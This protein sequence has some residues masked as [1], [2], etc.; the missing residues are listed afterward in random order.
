MKDA[1]FSFTSPLFHSSLLSTHIPRM[2]LFGKPKS[3]KE[4]IQSI[5]ENLLILSSSQSKPEKE[6]R[7]AV[8]NIAVSL[9]NLRELLT[10]KSDTR[11]TGRERDADL[12]NSERTRINEI[13]TDITHEL[14]NLN[15]LPLLIANLDAIEFES[16]KHVVDLFGH[17]MRRQVGSYN[18]CAQYLLANPNILV[19]LLHGYSRPDR[20]IHYGAILRDACRHES[21]A[22]VVLSSP[23]FYQL[24]DY[25]QGTAFDVSSDAF[26]TLKDL[27]TRHKTL[28]AEF[29]STNYD[30][31]FKHYSN[32]IAA[33]NYV[34]NRQALK[35]LG[36]LLL[37][38][39]NFSV[40]TR[41]IAD[42]EN[43]KIIMNLLKSE[44]KQ[45][46][47]EAFHCFKVFVA[48]P[49]KPQSVHMILFRNQEKLISFLSKFQ[50][51]RTDDGQFNHEKEYLIKQIRDLKA[52]P[53]SS[54][55]PSLAQVGSAARPT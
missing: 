3:P 14:I 30:E 37:E 21:L 45:I 50:T 48:N 38:R 51:E 41:Y 8:E 34:T 6:R 29:L 35:L 53:N 12:S 43:L 9:N 13:I 52:L 2:P 44:K 1:C 19:S 7:K 10:D 42:P 26:S 11:L 17:V 32:M 22:K 28:V 33:E 47:F 55:N 15:V 4:L 23:E 5:H 54:S 36:E 46:A 24:F 39:H 49:N 25:V 16:S 18:P 27:L 31:F 40:M 20:A